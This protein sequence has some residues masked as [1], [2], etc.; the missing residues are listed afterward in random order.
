MPA[1]GVNTT[2]RPLL[3]Y[4]IVLCVPRIHQLVV[5]VGGIGYGLFSS[6]SCLAVHLS[7]GGSLYHSDSSRVAVVN[8]DVQNVTEH[9]VFG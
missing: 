7:S 1:G 2:L 4:P 5:K 8:R 9:W 6:W 3:D